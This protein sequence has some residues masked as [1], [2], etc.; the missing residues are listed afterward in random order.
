MHADLND[1]HNGISTAPRGKRE[2]FNKD[3][4][5][6]IVTGCN[7]APYEEFTPIYVI[8]NLVV[9]PVRYTHIHLSFAYSCCPP[10]CF[11]GSMFVYFSSWLL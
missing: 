6:V 9:K 5:T 7:M 8:K 11:V 10:F 4:N 3:N 1:E 2:G